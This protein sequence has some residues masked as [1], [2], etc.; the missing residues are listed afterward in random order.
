MEWH[1]KK[2]EE[3]FRILKTSEKGLTEQEA[4]KRLKDGLNE[5]KEIYRINPV[6]IFLS[7]FKSFL[8]YILLIAALISIFIAHYLDASVIFAITLI[9]TIIG[10]VQQ[11][12]AETSIQKLKQLFV[13]QARIFRNGKL[14]L[15]SSKHIVPGDIILFEQGDKIT[16]DCR[17]LE[18]ENLEVNESILTGESNAVEKY[19]SLVSPDTILAERLNMLY[20]GTLVSRGKVTALVVSTAMSTEFGKIALKLQ[21]IETPQTPMQKKLD[22]FAKQVSIVIIAIAV[23]AFIIGSLTGIDKLEMFLTSITLIVAAIPEGLPAVITISL[24][25]ATKKMLKNN[26]LIRRLPAAETL[27]SV[28]IICTDKTGTI[29]EEK[30]VVKEIFCSNKEF[31]K[32]EKGIMFKNKLADFEKEKLLQQLISTSVLSSNARFEKSEEGYNIIGDTTEGAFVSFALG[33]GINRKILTEKEP[34]IKELSFSSERKMM[35]ILRKSDRRNVLYC[36]G[37]APVILEKSSFEL[38]PSGIEKLSLKRKEELGKISEEMEKQ[39]LRVL[40]FAFRNIKNEKEMEGSLI[41]QGFI[42]VQD[43]PRKEVYQALKDCRAAGIQVKMITGDSALTARAVASE[44]GIKGKIIDGKSLEAMSDQ[45]LL[46][47]IDNINI[48]ARIE[49]KQKLRIAEILMLKGEQVAMTGDG[50]NDILALKKADI[51]IA[52]GKRG[53]DIARD[54]S[55]MILIDDNFSSIVKGIEEGRV[56]YDNSKKATKFLLSSNLGELLLITLSVFMRLP[57]PL[58]PL[59]ILWINLV[60]DS[61]PALALT[62]EKSEDVMKTLPRKDTSLFNGIFFSMFLTALLFLISCFAI[63]YYSFNNFSIETART[64]TLMAVIGF[65]MFFIF[66]CRSDKPLYKIGFFSNHLLI[67]AVL[68]A[69]GMQLSL[70]YTPLSSLFSV[71]KLSAFQWLLVLLA[72]IPGLLVFEV[73]KLIKSKK[74]SK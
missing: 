37:A 1:A 58:L 70:I 50:V 44:I 29:T 68:L 60:T 33:Y 5:I 47:E 38:T 52:M 39:G 26:V 51:G 64:M 45:D 65:E 56:V 40:G 15:M 43:P 72:S 10:F 25:F 19:T 67:Y 11:Y 61:L 21:E 31:K 9:N 13:P 7:Q 20:T 34:R 49:P 3:L 14:K 23:L 55:D 36:K 12:K 28:T 42:G 24:A 62:R 48:F 69:L 66:S 18:S 74:S 30:M 53:S 17:I 22:R 35:S 6:K 71:V 4:E 8:I 41:F 57:L 2:K 73:I 54:V 63:F 27:G 46:A 59:H 32:T 16:A